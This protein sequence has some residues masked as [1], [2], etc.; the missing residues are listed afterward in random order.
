MKQK[1][2][3]SVILIITLLIGLSPSISLSEENK[4]AL[5]R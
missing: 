4:R 5:W 2:A 3:L 1:I